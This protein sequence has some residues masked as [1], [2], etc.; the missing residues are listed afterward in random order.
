[1]TPILSSPTRLDSFRAFIPAFLL[2][3]TARCTLLSVRPHSLTL[4][5]FLHFPSLVLP[6][7]LP[8]LPGFFSS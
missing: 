5:I 4:I 6:H 2:C 3:P 8:T 1:M 7:L